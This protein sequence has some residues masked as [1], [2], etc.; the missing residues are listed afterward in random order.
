MAWYSPDRV[1]Q[2]LNRASIVALRNN[3][4][5]SPG[6]VRIPVAGQARR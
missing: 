6:G 2:R 3:N 1:S 5:A 4:L